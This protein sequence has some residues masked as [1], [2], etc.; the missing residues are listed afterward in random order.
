M[1]TVRSFLLYFKAVFI[2]HVGKFQKKKKR[3][4]R[5][6]V[7]VH[8]IGVCLLAMDARFFFQVKAVLKV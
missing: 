3:I 2:M 1:F 6:I 4:E 8:F 5:K 7:L